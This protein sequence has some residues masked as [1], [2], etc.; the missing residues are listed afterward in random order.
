M[1]WTALFEV[2]VVEVAVRVFSSHLDLS[3]YFGCN[4]SVDR[5]SLLSEVRHDRL[6]Q[7]GLSAAARAC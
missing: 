4:Y 3:G 7:G 6:V 2:W 1:N 5:S